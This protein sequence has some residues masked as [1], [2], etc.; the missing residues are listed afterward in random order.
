MRVCSRIPN[1]ISSASALCTI[2][3]W[4]P[5]SSLNLE[6]VLRELLQKIDR[7]LPYPVV[8]VQLLNKKTGRLEPAACQNIDENEWKA[9]ARI[10]G[11]P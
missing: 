6:A 11:R 10:P 9:E 4:L 3:F 5:A 2:L 1:A 7:F 8:T